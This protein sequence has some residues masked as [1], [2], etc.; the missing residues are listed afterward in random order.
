MLPRMKQ[1]RKEKGISQQTLAEAMG[2]SQQSINNYENK[3]IEPD[4]AM[5]KK[6]AVYFDTTIDYILGYANT[7]YPI[8]DNAA[9]FLSESE[10]KLITHYRAL[11][12]RHRACVNQVIDTL[13]EE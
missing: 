10:G 6:M 5:L 1:L 7:R 13:L 4:I 9:Y 11:S 12:P 3:T 2:V 8:E